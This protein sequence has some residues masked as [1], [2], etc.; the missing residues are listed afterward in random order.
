MAHSTADVTVAAR[1]SSAVTQRSRFFLVMA[2]VLF[3]PVAIGFGPTFFLRPWSGAR[4]ALGGQFPMHLIIH[5]TV[6]SAW[7]VLFIAQPT[8]VAAQRVDLHRRLG[9]FGVGLAV[10]VVLA[11]I[12]TLV[13]VVPRATA[14]GASM[15]LIV[16]VVW[17]DTAALFTF[18][19]C[20]AGAVYFRRR[21]AVH[22]RLMFLAT[23]SIVGPA[24]SA[25]RPVG[26]A[27]MHWLPERPFGE[28]FVLACFAALVV[29]DVATR[30]RIHPATLFGIAVIFV[31]GI[32]AGA[33]V[34][35]T[36]LDAA[37]GAPPR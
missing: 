34:H 33:V 15:N 26:R 19:A 36:G 11:S 5:G 13:R 30:R 2:I 7:F 14:G 37:L 20:V 1:A 31:A 9:V 22:A 4:D 6:L 35:L 27:L 18:V 8:L 21:P 23:A 28:Y 25:A 10:A 3:V 24:F 16:G 29:Y 12:V 17:V 32:A